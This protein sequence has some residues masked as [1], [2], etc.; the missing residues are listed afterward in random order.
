MCPYKNSTNYNLI[1]Q[2]FLTSELGGPSREEEDTESAGP[3]DELV[4]KEDRLRLNE[5]SPEE[6]KKEEEDAP[7]LLPMSSSSSS[8]ALA[9]LESSVSDPATLS[10]NLRRRRPLSLLAWEIA[11]E[12]KL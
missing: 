3:S 12:L 10:K 2:F 11:Q 9:I 5:S 8:S 7:L 6:S 4:A 1:W